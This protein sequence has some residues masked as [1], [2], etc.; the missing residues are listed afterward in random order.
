MEQFLSYLVVLIAQF[1]AVM[2]VITVH[3]YAHA[4]VAYKFGDPTAKFAGRM[5]LNP[6]RHFDPLGIVMFAVVGFGWAKPVPINPNNFNNYKKGSLWTSSA[7][8]IAN[9]LMAFLFY[10]LFILVV[11]YI[12]PPLYGKYMASFLYYLFNGLVVFSLSFCVFNL[13]PFYPLDGFRIVDATNNRR[14][15]VYWFLKQNGYQILLGLILIHFLAGRIP[16]LGYID[17]LGYALDFAIGVFGRP[18]TL[19]WNWIFR[20]FGLNVPFIF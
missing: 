6:M 8:V 18:I 13:L 11:Y 4:F 10:P 19:F 2:A 1:L 12:L 7:G 14:G 5:S 3:E 16:V 15:K 17:I 9:Y 20:L